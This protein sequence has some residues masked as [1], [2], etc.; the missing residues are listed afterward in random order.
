[1]LSKWYGNLA[2]TDRALVNAAMREAVELAIFSFLC[3]LDGVSAIENG[4]EKGDLRLVYGKD[5]KELLLNDPSQEFLHD[6]FNA[7]CQTS[8]PIAPERSEAR[9]YEVNSAQH[10]RENQT[11]TDGLD[12]H[13]VSPV[14]PKTSH[15]ETPSITLPKNEH[16][17]L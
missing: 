4:P 8:E 6:L 14:D 9:M 1:M 13:S 16:R 5:G 7:L 17:K 2:S 12:L 10:L 3:V 15:R 11:S